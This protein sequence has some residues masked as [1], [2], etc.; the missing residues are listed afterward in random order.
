M[1][2]SR[3]IPAAAVLLA[4]VPGVSRAADATAKPAVPRFN[5]AYMD[6]TVDPRVDFARY[7]FGHWREANP[8]PADKSRWG[9]FNEL[10]LYN[11]TALKGILE[12]AAA[13]SHE[14]GSVEQKVGDFYAAAMNTKAI[15]AAREVRDAYVLL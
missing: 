4:L 8:I 7:A 1:L 5:V 3:L 6:R 13:R 10:D 11:Q 2:K 15:D 14:P 12:T 9:A